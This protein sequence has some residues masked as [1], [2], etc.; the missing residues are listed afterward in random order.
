MEE[1]SW[2]GVCGE[3]E[4]ITND[5]FVKLLARCSALFTCRQFV[6]QSAHADSSSSSQCKPH[7]Y[8]NK[9]NTL[10]AGLT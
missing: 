2:L 10:S 1:E 3:G 9:F 6:V 8:T 5:D 7:V 4:I